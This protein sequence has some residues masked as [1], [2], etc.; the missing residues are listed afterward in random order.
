MKDSDEKENNMGK[1]DIQLLM[2]LEERE[3]G[4]MEEE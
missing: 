1:D 3:N 4:R 2:E